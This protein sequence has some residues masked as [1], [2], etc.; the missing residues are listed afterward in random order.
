LAESEQIIAKSLD[1]AVKTEVR[2]K[3]QADES[4]RLE[5]TLNKE[6]WQK[7]NK[8]RELL[9]HQLTHGSWDQVIEYVAER[10]I[11]SKTKPCK[12][13]TELRNPDLENQ[14][15]QAKTS[16]YKLRKQVL[17]RDQCCQYRDPQTR[18]LC[19]SR[20]QLQVDH[21]QPRWADGKDELTNLRALCAQLNRQIYRWQSGISQRQI[22]LDEE[23]SAGF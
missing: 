6:Q 19:A 16:F 8:M 15:T 5:V 17:Q 13:K 12:P 14:S 21:I 2:L 7:L 20:W 3:H 23:P 4:V 10:V 18:K 9:S 11:A 1:L 22:F